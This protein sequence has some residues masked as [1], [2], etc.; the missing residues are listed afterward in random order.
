MSFRSIPAGVPINQPE[1]ITEIEAICNEQGIL[2][3]DMVREWKEMKKENG[4]YTKNV[5]G[6]KKYN[7]EELNKKMEEIWK[8]D[9]SSSSNKFIDKNGKQTDKAA[10]DLKKQL[11]KTRQEQLEQELIYVNKE[12][13]K[14]NGAGLSKWQLELRKKKLGI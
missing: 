5:V 4:V 3:Q 9:E 11:E 12:I 10:D 1:W 2:P 13:E 7:D 14:R 6:N 8:Q